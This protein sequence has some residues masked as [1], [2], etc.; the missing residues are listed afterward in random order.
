MNRSSLPS[1]SDFMPSW[2]FGLWLL[3]IIGGPLL[4]V[5]VPRAPTQA[6]ALCLAAVA[7]P[8]LT[9]R[10]P[11]VSALQRRISALTIL[12][13]SGLALLTLHG[14]QN[15]IPRAVS[16]PLLLVCIAAAASATWHRRSATPSSSSASVPGT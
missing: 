4:L 11:V 10:S 15:A 1:D 14:N 7:I 16:A 9:S 3:G 2:A 8:G 5:V 12:G 6:A 13:F